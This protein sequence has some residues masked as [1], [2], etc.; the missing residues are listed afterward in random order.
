MSTQEEFITILLIE[1][2]LSQYQIIMTPVHNFL[3]CVCVYVCVSH[4]VMSM[5]MKTIKHD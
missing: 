1:S 4:L 2:Q 3:I 5:C